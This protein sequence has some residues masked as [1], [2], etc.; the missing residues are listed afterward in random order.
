VIY[1]TLSTHT[2]TSKALNEAA[3]S[4]LPFARNVSNKIIDSNWTDQ[5]FLLDVY[6]EFSEFL[7]SEV[8]KVEDSYDRRIVVIVDAV[9]LRYLSADSDGLRWENL[10]ALLILSFPDITWCF[11]QTFGSNQGFGLDN[12]TNRLDLTPLFD[13]QGLRQFIRSKAPVNSHPSIIANRESLA[14][15]IDDEVEIA[16]LHAY[17]LYRS[18]YRAES[19]T[20]NRSMHSLLKKEIN[21]LVLT[22]EDISLGFSDKPASEHYSAN[23]ERLKTFPG[24]AKPGLVRVIIT[25]GRT[26]SENYRY[27]D[28]VEYKPLGGIIDICNLIG[29]KRSVSP[30]LKRLADSDSIVGQGDDAFRHSAPGRLMLISSFLLHRIEK[31]SSSAVSTQRLLTQAIFAQ[32]ALELTAGRSPAVSLAALAS[33]HRLEVMAEQQFVAIG[34][35]SDQTARIDEITSDCKAITR[36]YYGSARNVASLN[37]QMSIVSTLL[38]SY[39]DDGKYEE[40]AMYSNHSSKIEHS[41]RL[42]LSLQMSENK[43]NSPLVDRLT[44]N[45][46]S[47]IRWAFASY[48]RVTSTSLLHLFLVISIWIFVLSASFVWQGSSIRPPF[49]TGHVPWDSWFYCGLPEAISS[50]FSAGPPFRPTGELACEDKDLLG[51]RGY[52]TVV[53]ISIASGALHMGIFVAMIVSRINRK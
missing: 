8:M 2:T 48:F 7:D 41:L 47:R 27:P 11:G 53:S 16:Y 42:A 1:L 20:T 46:V 26:K 34:F 45:I 51:L 32:D 28:G 23:S 39:R 50:F 13:G 37:A 3:L 29:G 30:K 12:L 4:K 49:S 35:H 40:E 19:I 44:R 14:I 25:T 18:G 38:K 43:P 24:L 31:R 15:A 22:L 17:S 21:E 36:W 5:S 52:S 33:M 10:I 6:R 9:D